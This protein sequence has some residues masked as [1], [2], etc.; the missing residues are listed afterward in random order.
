MTPGYRHNHYVP[1]WY[2]RR[3]LAEGQSRYH[4]LDLHPDRVTNNGHTYIRNASFRW[5][6]RQCFAQNDLYTTKWG[7]L[8]NR[9]IERFF[10]GAVDLAGKEAVEHFAKFEFT[11]ATQNAWNALVQ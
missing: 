1:E 6:P 4:Y 3:F 2:Q 10:F 5:G 7:G 11:A 9:D 8:E